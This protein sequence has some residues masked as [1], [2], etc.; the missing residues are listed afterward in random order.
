M[1][2]LVRNIHIQLMGQVSSQPSLFRQ[3]HICILND[4]IVSKVLLFSKEFNW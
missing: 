2:F 1:A 4:A 3:I